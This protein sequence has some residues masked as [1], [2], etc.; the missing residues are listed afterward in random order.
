MRRSKNAST[1]DSSAHTQRV[2]VCSAFFIPMSLLVQ[3]EIFSPFPPLVLFSMWVKFQSGAFKWEFR[4]EMATLHT[5]LNN[6]FG[7]SH[8]LQSANAF[9]V[10]SCQ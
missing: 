3:H 4:P 7:S 2:L 9:H 1:Q 6:G 8:T 10:F 5:R